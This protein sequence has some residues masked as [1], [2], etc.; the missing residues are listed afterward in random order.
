MALTSPKPSEL[1][2]KKSLVEVTI[3]N[4]ETSKSDFFSEIFFFYNFNPKL[5]IPLKRV[6]HFLNNSEIGMKKE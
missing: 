4:F 3:R 5:K 2:E 6:G 1:A